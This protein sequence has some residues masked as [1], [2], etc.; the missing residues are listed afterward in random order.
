MLTYRCVLFLQLHNSARKLKRKREAMARESE[1][2]GSGSG[3]ED[4]GG[5]AGAGGG[6]SNVATMTTK[7][8]RGAHATHPVAN[9]SGM[10]DEHAKTLL[11]MMHD[12][13]HK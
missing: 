9:I 5:G 3:G 8:G 2:G 1:D 7:K 4:G 13:A 10:N 12:D 6:E 11:L